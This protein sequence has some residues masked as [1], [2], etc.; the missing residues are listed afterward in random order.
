MVACLTLMKKSLKQPP[1]EKERGESLNFFHHHKPHNNITNNNKRHHT[2]IYS[3][4]NTEN[5]QHT[6]RNHTQNQNSLP[7]KAGK[8]TNNRVNNT[9]NMKNKN[10]DVNTYYIL[11]PQ[12]LQLSQQYDSDKLY[13]SQEKE[14]ETNDEKNLEHPLST[15]IPQTRPILNL[16][17][18]HHHREYKHHKSKINR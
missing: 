17:Q 10:A 15:D 2:G 7:A 6:I 3:S 11:P 4:S 9:N 1:L 18:Q 12:Y 16:Y 8:N 13:Q 14:D 5:I